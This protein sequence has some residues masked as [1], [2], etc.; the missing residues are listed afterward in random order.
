MSGGMEQFYEVFFEEAD[1]L[2][3]SMESEL[4]EMI[5]DAD[6]PE[7]IN[8]VFRAAH[9]IKGGAAT[10]GFTAM[11]ETT[12]VMETLMDQVRDGSMKATRDL[13]DLL[14]RGVD[15]VQALLAAAKSGEEPD[16]ERAAAMQ[17]ELQAFLDNGGAPEESPAEE[18]PEAPATTAEPAGGPRPGDV[19]AAATVALGS[20]RYRYQIEFKPSHDLF[21]TGNDPLHVFRALREL[22]DLEVE[23][24]ADS[25]PALEDFDPHKLYLSW[26][27][28]LDSDVDQ[29]V[30]QEAFD[31]VEDACEIHIERVDLTASETAGE[32]V[33]SAAGHGG[34][35]AAADSAD[36]D[37]SPRFELTDSVSASGASLDIRRLGNAADVHRGQLK[38]MSL[39][40]CR[41]N[42]LGAMEPPLQVDE[43]LAETVL[44][45]SGGQ[46]VSLTATVRHTAFDPQQQLT[47]CGLQFVSIADDQKAVLQRYLSELS[48]QP[49]SAKV[50]RAP[51]K[52]GAGETSSIRV[53]IDKIDTL[54]NLV[55]E[56]VIT[57]SMLGQMGENLESCDQ[58]K[59]REG[60]AQLERHTRELQEN[61]MQ[62]RMVPISNVFN[63][64][65]RMIHDLSAKLGKKINLQVF[66]EQTELDKTV[67]EKIGDPLV[68]LVRN[69]ID[70]GIE[71]PEVRTTAGKP[72]EGQLQLRAYHADG[73]IVIEI[74][75]DGAGLNAE[76]ILQKARSNGL[77]GE[78]ENLS[79]QRI[80]ELIF[81]P[82]FSTAEAVSDVSGRG[83]GMD[84]VRR[85]IQACG[86][87]VE[88][89][90]EQ[91]AGSVFTIR[92][93]L[94]LAIVDGQLIQV[95]DQIYVIPLVSI[96]ESIQLQESNLKSIAELGQ[97]YRIRGEYVP[98][99]QLTRLFNIPVGEDAQ[100][101]PLLVVVESGKGK[102]GLLVDDLLAQQQVVVKSLESNY[103]RIEGISG[104]TILGDGTVSLIMDIPSLM[105]L[106]NADRALPR[107]DVEGNV[108]DLN[109]A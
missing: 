46:V 33:T 57:Q 61:V 78:H 51:R 90:S 28:Q 60:F 35:P 39:G 76:R 105:T 48:K 59:L 3:E 88:V 24:D 106:A 14:L 18:A 64:L 83:V 97:V 4:L 85:N 27:L 25:L 12:H 74:R 67:M 79:E 50:S 104:A 80:H 1:E 5:F 17:Q 44:Q 30:V 26:Q 40:G 22:G 7:R 21:K 29:E 87:G 81:E 45:L 47:S 52:S 2:I 93:P 102:I 107:T 54:I 31:W 77:V 65:P 34:Q 36:P 70:H 69:A 98:V 10:F 82:G 91:G 15:V 41:V 71:Q 56:L 42:F 94:T 43:Q 101:E 13:V 100:R 8:T 103:R 75:D 95:A 63:R 86:G 62:I 20:A 23:V 32:A 11:A 38:D 96:V 66:G 9:S 6:D 19:E 55:G 68:H 73:N 108:T 58:E 37:D 84:V 53:G 49:E 16:G 92:L 89:Q 109:A 72:A 99:V